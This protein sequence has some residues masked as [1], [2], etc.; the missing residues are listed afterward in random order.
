MDAEVLVA[1]ATSSDENVEEDDEKDK[2]QIIASP[3]RKGQ[4][5]S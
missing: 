5:Y 2:T 3:K 1:S 4:S